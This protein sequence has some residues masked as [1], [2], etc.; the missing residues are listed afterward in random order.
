MLGEHGLGKGNRGG[1]G[2]PKT[3]PGCGGCRGVHRAQ[4]EIGMRAGGVYPIREVKASWNLGEVFPVNSPISR[5][6]FS[7][8]N[9][10]SRWVHTG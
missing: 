10:K 2:R 4:Q 9:G 5:V 1:A 8:M 3:V 7:R 6:K